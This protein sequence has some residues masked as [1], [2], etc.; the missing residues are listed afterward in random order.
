MGGTSATNLLVLGLFGRGFGFPVKHPWGIRSI[1]WG[2]LQQIEVVETA[3]QNAYSPAQNRDS[4]GICPPFMGNNDD[5]M[6]VPWGY[7]EPGGDHKNLNWDVM[8]IL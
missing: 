8:D 2:P 6:G 5:V 1:F 7:D 3:Q 4:S